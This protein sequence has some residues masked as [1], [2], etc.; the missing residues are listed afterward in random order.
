MSFGR[1][2]GTAPSGIREGWQTHGLSH[3]QYIV[4]LLSTKRA[5]PRFMHYLCMYYLLPGGHA[6]MYV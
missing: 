2:A 6:C 3:M 5:E 4:A 1:P